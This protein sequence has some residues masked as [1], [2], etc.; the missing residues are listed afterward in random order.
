[1]PKA[2]IKSMEITVTDGNGQGCVPRPRRAV[3]WTLS[4]AAR[5]G[6][7]PGFPQVSLVTALALPHWWH[8]GA[9]GVIGR[10]LVGSWVAT[11]PHS[12]ADPHVLYP[13]P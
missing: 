8:P 3:G 7:G 6:K 10:G 12:L 11:G 2:K 5:W 1:M 13:C 4:V 9:C